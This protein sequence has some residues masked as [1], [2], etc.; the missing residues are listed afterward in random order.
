[1]PPLLGSATGT[2]LPLGNITWSDMVFPNLATGV[3]DGTFKMTF[4]DGDTLFGT[5]REQGDFPPFQSYL[6]HNS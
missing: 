6:S 5:L 2:L 3:G 1:M 4:T